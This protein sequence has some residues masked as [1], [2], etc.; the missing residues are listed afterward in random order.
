MII[1]NS[2]K[3]SLV[4][5]ELYTLVNKYFLF[6]SN[7]AN[8]PNNAGGNENC[9]AMYDGGRYNDLPCDNQAYFICEKPVRKYQKFIS[10]K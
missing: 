10:P 4:L 7:W 6:F 8:E 9:A 5:K 3:G 1:E 2:E